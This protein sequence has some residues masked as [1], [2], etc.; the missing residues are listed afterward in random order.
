MHIRSLAIVALAG[1]FLAG[2]DGDAVGAAK[3][4]PRKAQSAAAA[5]TQAPPPAPPV[6][7]AEASPP[8][9][10]TFTP[11]AAM[12]V[13]IVERPASP[14]KVAQAIVLHLAEA[15][16]CKQLA[17]RVDYAA[18]Q[19][20]IS[21]GPKRCGFSSSSALRKGETVEIQVPAVK[22]NTAVTFVAPASAVQIYD[23]STDVQKAS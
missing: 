1:A 9:V 13:Q 14:P 21:L 18:N 15:D 17:R 10:T 23:I 5:P 12:Q 22:G 3:Q 20:L 2:C 8:K 16:G 11:V 6:Q 4:E 7:A 19:F